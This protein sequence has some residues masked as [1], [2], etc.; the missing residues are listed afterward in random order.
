LTI[1]RIVYIIIITGCNCPFVKFCKGAFTLRVI[2]GSARGLKLRSL[3]GTETRPTLDRVKEAL[4]SMLFARC[5]GAQA[6]DLFAGSGAL[7]IELLSRGGAGC[8]FVDSS[9]DALEV[10]RANVCSARFLDKSSIV[11]QDAVSFAKSTTDKYDIIFLDPPYRSQLYEEILGI[12][13]DRG[14][15]KDKGLAICECERDYEI[16]IGGF[17]PVKDKSYG[18]VRLLILEE[19]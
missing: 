7:G 3:D 17:L 15:L 18:K 16:N 6:L 9:S 2:S 4:F 10:I 14:L 5:E 8:T 12:I 13:K 1:G 11:R 19:A